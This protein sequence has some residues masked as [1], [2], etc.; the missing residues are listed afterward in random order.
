MLLDD[1]NLNCNL[2]GYLMAFAPAGPRTVAVTNGKGGVGKTTTS[3]HL[4]SLTAASGQKVLLV[5]LD[6]QGNCG[7]DLGYTDTDLDDNGDSLV[8]A[9]LSKGRTA[10]RLARVR[11]NLDVIVGGDSLDD[12]A[13]MLAGRQRRESGNGSAALLAETL[14]PLID[15]YALVV[16]DCP[17]RHEVLEISALVAARYVVIP[18]RTDASSV[19]GL[20]RVAAKFV[21]ARE[22]NPAL[23]LLGVVMYGTNPSAT[24]IRAEVRQRLEEALQEAAPVFDATVRYTEATAYDIR[25]RGQLSHELEAALLDGSER[26]RL[27][28]TKRRAAAS[29]SKTLAADF[30]AL[31][32]EIVQGVLKREAADA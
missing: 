5:D 21:K 18:T 30:D 28:G 8:A 27:R 17:P 22:V 4:A 14:A 10:P 31:T 13:D 9:V 16:L 7:E 23:E 2:I 25:E 26:E 29:A 6:P 11:D 24:R 15:D 20:R 3:T 1:C 32:T 19:K 12:L